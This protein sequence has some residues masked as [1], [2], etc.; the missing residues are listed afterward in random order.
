VAEVPPVSSLPAVPTIEQ[1]LL[2]LAERDEALVER[3]EA[4]V[5]R[6]RLI[7]RLAER[8]AVSK[9]IRNCPETDSNLFASF[10]DGARGPQRVA[11][12]ARCVSTAPEC[13]ALAC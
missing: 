4:L 1:L 6:D 5:E 9:D 13:S 2:L 10:D 7:A 11:G 12:S 3:D 8:V